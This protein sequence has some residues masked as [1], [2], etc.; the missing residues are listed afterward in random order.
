MTTLANRSSIVALV[1]AY[2]EAL[3]SIREGFAKLASAEK[4]L[5]SAF[6]IGDTYDYVRIR[7]P[8]SNR[9]YNVDDIQPVLDLIKKDIWGMLVEHV[10]KLVTGGWIAYQGPNKGLDLSYKEALAE[11]RRPK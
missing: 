4:L 2:E 7:E 1:R 8:Y 11:E 10:P 5:N 6:S 3:V 9:S